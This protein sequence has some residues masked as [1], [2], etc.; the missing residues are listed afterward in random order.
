MLRVCAHVLVIAVACC[1]AGD[2]RADDET[3][4]AKKA[5]AAKAAKAKADADVGSKKAA[6]AKKA[7]A[8]KAAQ[9]KADDIAVAKKK[10]QKKTGDATREK[11]VVRVKELFKKLDANGDGVLTFEEFTGDKEAKGK[12]A[13]KPAKETADAKRSYANDKND[14]A[15]TSKNIRAAVKAGKL[16]KEEAKAKLAAIKKTA[17][18]KRGYAKDKNDYDAINKKLKASVKAG[19]LTEEEARAKLAAIKKAADAKDKRDD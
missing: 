11:E 19:K 9:A 17:D 5:A 8:D 13:K 1:P 7:A 16:T 6:A 14:Y 3:A 10:S 18:A 15:A 2:L 4:A 12:K